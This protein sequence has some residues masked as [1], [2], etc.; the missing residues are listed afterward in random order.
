KTR[1]R[2]FCLFWKVVPRRGLEPPRFYPLVP[3]TSASTN[4][5]TW[6]SRAG[7][8]GHRAPSCQRFPAVCLRHRRACG[9]D[10]PFTSTAAT[11]EADENQ[12]TKQ[13]REDL[14]YHAAARH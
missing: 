11:M 8:S 3:E 4:S 9:A 13:G 6:A 14:P 1:F 7:N 2:G 5:A 10:P 12:K